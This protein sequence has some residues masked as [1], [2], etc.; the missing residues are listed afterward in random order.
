MPIQLTR[1]GSSGGYPPSPIK[2]NVTGILSLFANFCKVFVASEITI[3][4]PP[5]TIGRLDFIIKLAAFF[6][7]LLVAKIGTLYPLTLSTG[8][9]SNL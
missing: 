2:V 6:I 7:S 1:I 8:R 4:P 9:N 5:K 3:P